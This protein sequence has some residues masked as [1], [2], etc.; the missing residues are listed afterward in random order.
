MAVV[1]AICYRQFIPILPTY[2]RGEVANYMHENDSPVIH[3][4]FTVHMLRPLYVFSN[5]SDPSKRISQR[6]TF[7]QLM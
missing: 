5:V 7:E 2:E 3:Q 6:W 4:L 1:M